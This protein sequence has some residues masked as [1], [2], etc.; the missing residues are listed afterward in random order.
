[1][2]N[3]EVNGGITRI[4]ILK[5]GFKRGVLMELTLHRDRSLLLVLYYQYWNFGFWYKMIS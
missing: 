5:F 1:M 3:Y 2:V 4:C